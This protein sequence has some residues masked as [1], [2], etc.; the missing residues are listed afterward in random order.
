MPDLMSAL[1]ASLD[2]VRERTGDDGASSKPKRQRGTASS[3]RAPRRSRAAKPRRTMAASAPRLRRSTAPRPALRRVRRGRGFSIIGLDG[4]RVQD[5]EVLA[6][7]NEL[8]YPP[9]WKDVWICPYPGGHIQATGFDQRGRKQYLYH[10]RWRA[11]RD[12]QKFADMI[13]FARTLPALRRRVAAMARGDFSRDH[14]L[15]LAV[16]LLD[17]GFFRIGS[18][19]YA[20]TNESY[21]L[22]TMR[23]AHVVVDGDTLRFDY[24]AKHGKRRVQAVVDPDVAADVARLKRRRGG[25]RRAAG[26]SCPPA[27]A[28]ALDRRALARHQR[29]AQGGD[30]GRCQREGLP[31]VGGDGAGRRRPGGQP[32]ARQQDGTPAGDDPRRQRS[33]PLPRQHAGGGPGVVHRSPH[34]RSIPRRHHHRR[35]AAAARSGG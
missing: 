34:V 19:D 14:V 5:A 20:V 1:K 8:V 3:G 30:G 27:R 11:R 17:R 26:L 2:A 9:A 23:K 4:K 10:P 35:H 22:A 6:R 24:P 28:W 13:V 29:V 32:G 15:A 25:G 31:H 16:R 7:V 33:R 21:G 12:Q 18:E